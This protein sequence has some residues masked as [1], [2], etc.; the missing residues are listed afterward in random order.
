MAATAPLSNSQPGLR[1]NKGHRM[2]PPYLMTR[3]LVSHN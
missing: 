1:N 2:V 3:A